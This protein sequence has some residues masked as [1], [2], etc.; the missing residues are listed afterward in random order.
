MAAGPTTAA[1][2]ASSQLSA[3]AIAGIVVG[4]VALKLAVVLLVLRCLGIRK[5]KPS[6]PAWQLAKEARPCCSAPH[7]PWLCG[8]NQPM[9][10]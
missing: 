7:L 3:G 1:K 6:K 8:H 4:A 5:R 9:L 2:D 10:S